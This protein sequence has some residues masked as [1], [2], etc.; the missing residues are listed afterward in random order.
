[1]KTI[2]FFFL[3]IPNL[4]A[5]PNCEREWPSEDIKRS[6]SLK[7]KF[8]GK[9]IVLEAGVFKSLCGL[10]EGQTSLKECMVIRTCGLGDDNISSAILH[11]RPEHLKSLCLTS[12]PRKALRVAK[13]TYVELHCVGNKFSMKFIAGKKT[14][15]CPFPFSMP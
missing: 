5:S 12:R 2:L 14:K 3:F 15:T 1:M 10:Y 7:T 11:N 4:L 8:K 6:C 9:D 13:D